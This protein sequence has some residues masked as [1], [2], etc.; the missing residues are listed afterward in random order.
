[1]H[2]PWRRLAGACAAILLLKIP[3]AA[4]GTLHLAPDPAAAVEICE[5]SSAD[6]TIEQATQN[7]QAGNAEGLRLRR[8][9]LSTPIFSGAGLS[10][11]NP[12]HT[13]PPPHD[14]PPSS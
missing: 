6:V 4:A 3:P 11:G 1:M 9:L 2:H 7:T 8:L 12:Q 13:S 10:S 5:A 14:H